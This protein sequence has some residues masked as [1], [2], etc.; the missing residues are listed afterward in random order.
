MRR[1]YSEDLRLHA[2]KAWDNGWSKT[3]V[4]RTYKLARTTLDAWLRLRCEKGH[5]RPNT[6]Y[7]RG[8]VPQLPATAQV[9]EFIQRHSHCTLSQFSGAWEKETGQKLSRV[10]L[11]NR[12]RALGYTRKKR[13]ISTKSEKKSNVAYFWSNSP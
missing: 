1:A 12:L 6:T 2:L 10:T 3:Q 13:V 11:G 4:C 7:L 5:V 8:R 9:H